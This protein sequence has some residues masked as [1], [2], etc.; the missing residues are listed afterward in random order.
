MTIPPQSKHC[1]PLVLSATHKQENVIMESI[2]AIMMM[3][4]CVFFLPF[5]SIL[6]LS[7]H[8]V[9]FVTV[10]KAVHTLNG[11]T[12]ALL[13]PRVCITNTRKVSVSFLMFQGKFRSF[14]SFISFCSKCP[15]TSLFPEYLF[16]LHRKC[17]EIKIDLCVFLILLLFST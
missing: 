15:T 2:S 11:K 13:L 17:V 7:V 3:F 1:E 16:C 6:V 10:V 8:V 9:K 12:S 4:F 5:L 14:R